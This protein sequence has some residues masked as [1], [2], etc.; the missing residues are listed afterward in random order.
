MKVAI[1]VKFKVN[2]NLRANTILL[3]NDFMNAKLLRA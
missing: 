3:S 2:K 1:V